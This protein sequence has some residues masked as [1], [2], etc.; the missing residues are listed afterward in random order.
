[1]WHA[2]RCTKAEHAAAGREVADALRYN[3]PG[4]GQSPLLATPFDRF[5]HAKGL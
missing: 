5:L 2:A 3:L 1:M 4:V